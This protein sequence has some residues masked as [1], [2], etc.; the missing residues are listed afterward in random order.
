M[1]GPC[2]TVTIG[3]Q[4]KRLT[5]RQAHEYL[6]ENGWPISFSHFDWLCTPSI[7]KGPRVAG[8]FGSRVLYTPEDLDAWA[9]ARFKLEAA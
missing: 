1:K 7:G 3:D 2:S 5:R 4:V 6:N 9:Q 8:R